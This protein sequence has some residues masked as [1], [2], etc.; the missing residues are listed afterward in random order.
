M[1]AFRLEKKRIKRMKRIMRILI[2]C[3]VPEMSG[4]ESVASA[5]RQAFESKCRVYGHAPTVEVITR[6]DRARVHGG[7]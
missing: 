6:R 4:M 1:C 5:V 2:I 7:D 3:C